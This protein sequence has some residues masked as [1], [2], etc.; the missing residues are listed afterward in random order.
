[1]DGRRILHVSTASHVPLAKVSG[2][3]SAILQRP[4][5]RWSSVV[6]EV[7]L[8]VLGI[9]DTLLQEGVD[10]PP[11]WIHT[12]SQTYSRRRTDGTRRIEL[13]QGESFTG[14]LVDI[15][16]V[17]IIATKARR[18]RVAH[19]INVQDDDVGPLCLCQT[20]NRKQ[21]C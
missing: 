10:A 8:L 4:G 2:S 19:I 3:I 6:E 1:M 14:Q 16:R 12:S 5:H 9:V 7:V 17:D 13:L 20:E 11:G 15:G 21:R 18:V